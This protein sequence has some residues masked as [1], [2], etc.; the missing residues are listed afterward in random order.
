MKRIL[1]LA[2]LI[3][4]AGFSQAPAGYYN[5]TAGLTGYALKTKVSEIIS[6]NYNWNYG[7]L[8]GFYN[9]T[10]LDIYDDHDVSNTTILMDIYS[11]IIGGPDAYEYT[12]AQLIGNASAE[13]MGYNRE[14]IMPQ[15][16][17]YSY[18][19]MYSDLHTVIP[20]DARINQLRSNYP[21]A[22]GGATN[23]YVFSNTSRISND[24][25]P[26]Y[27]YT[28]RVYEPAPEFRGDLARI[29]LYF[30]VRYEAKLRSFNYAPGT[31]VANDT[32]PFNGTAEYA[33]DPGYLEMLKQW[34]AADPVSQRETDRN[35]A[36]YT[37][38][39]NRNPFVDNPQW[40]NLMWSETPDAV[41]P[42]APAN[43]TVNQ[44]GAHFV[45][46]SW[47][48]SADADVLGYKIFAD[49]STEPVAVTKSTSISIDQLTPS[50]T[51]SFT[52]KSYDKGYLES[53]VSN[54]ISVTTA[55]SDGFAR[56]LM[57]TKY[58]E[59]SSNNK[60]IEIVN[61]TGHEVNLNNYH[62]RI[63]NYNSVNGNYYFAEA[64][65]MEGTA[66]PGEVFVVL[67]PKA[68]L[69]CST[70]EQ[71]KFVTASDPLTFSGTQYIELSYRNQFTVDAI[72]V[73]D[74]MNNLEDR[75]LYRINATQPTATFAAAEWQTYPSDYCTNLGTLS[76]VGTPGNSFSD[77]S[78]YPNP[79][80]H[81]LFVNGSD[82]LK[83]Q[84]AKIYDMT[85]SLI[86]N[87]KTPFKIH[88]SLDVSTLKPGVYMLILDG[89][90]FKFI[91]H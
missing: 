74:T 55:A 76:V 12:A 88:K 23:H 78:I 9:Q 72:G 52:V 6:R 20:V 2:V 75:S 62:L 80:K 49:G 68:A 70:N 89:Q 40:V 51:Y 87:K 56:D 58:I 7:D 24:L 50:T 59:G 43:L 90:S 27:A 84:S 10:D 46:L 83:I 38:Q 91:K 16:T 53:P 34:H 31:T 8:P 81:E 79:V 63:Q 42:Q 69:G 57:I 33:F 3:P 77:V 71:A 22:T 25:T 11:E 4:F 15:S 64:F 18:Y 14:H 48:P 45:T 13:G 30:A 86:F 82:I 29:I 35:N 73:R 32:N 85:G 1:L 19:P 41:P 39:K 44:S 5:G 26:G 66:A 17:F 28:G 36:V 67:N 47:T 54:A 60:A 61:N 65:Q 21:I 37:I